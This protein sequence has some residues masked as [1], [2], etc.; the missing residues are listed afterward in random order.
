MT[1]RVSASIKVGGVLAATQLTEFINLI[2]CEGLGP[3]WD[4][5]FGNEAELRT[6]LADGDAGVTFY[7]HEVRGGE[8]EDL[9]AFCVIQGSDPSRTSSRTWSGSIC[10]K[11]RRSSSAAKPTP[12][13]KAPR[14]EP[15]E[16]LFHA[17][18]R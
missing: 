9:Q 15:H 3:D 6:Y 18:A 12:S 8:F 11:R 5:G 10:R 14:H 13:F 2:G 1:D 7:A 16:R 17:E 4:E